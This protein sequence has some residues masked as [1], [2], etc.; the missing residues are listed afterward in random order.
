[1]MQ[2]TE[3]GMQMN[4]FTLQQKGFTL[5]ELMIV[6]AIIGILASIA[7]PNY[8][9]YIKKGK[10]AEATS[11]L[12]NLRI[13]ME[14]CFQDN[15]DYS[16]AAC[17]AFCTATAGNFTYACSPLST[18]TTYK[19]VASGVAAKGMTNFSYSVDQSNAKTSSYDGAASVNCWVSSKGASC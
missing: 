4:K 14:Q 8:K 18:A 15:R 3:K 17:T 16:V 11:T 7:L 2:L 1:M 12:A 19:I 6:V 9:E 13:K 10:A 5:I